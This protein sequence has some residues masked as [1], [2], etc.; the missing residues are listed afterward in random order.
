MHDPVS[1][2]ASPSEAIGVDQAA[3]FEGFFRGQTQNFVR[4]SPP[5]HGESG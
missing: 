2:H 4:A 5:D 1:A 3:A